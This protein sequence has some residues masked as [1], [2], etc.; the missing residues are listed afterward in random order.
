[1]VI[2]R[3]GKSEKAIRLIGRVT[4]NLVGKKMEGKEDPVE[5]REVLMKA[6]VEATLLWPRGG[7]GEKRSNAFKMETYR[8]LLL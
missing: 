5:L 8:R 2:P 7:G 4:R 1:M 3:N 6:I